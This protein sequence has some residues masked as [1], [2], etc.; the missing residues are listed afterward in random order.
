MKISEILGEIQNRAP[1]G[2]AES[3]DNVGLLAGDLDQSTRGAVVAI[4]LNRRAIEIARKKKFSLI[5][6]HHPAIFPTHRGLSRVVREEQ[7]GVSSLVY[8]AIHSGISVVACHTNFDRCALEVV[9]AVAHG[10]GAEPEG[11][12]LEKGGAGSLAKLSVFVPKTHAERVRMAVCEAGAGQIGKYDFC[13]FGT[14]GI[15]TFR[16]SADTRPFKGKPGRLEKAQEI[17]LETLVPRGLERQVVAALLKAH[18]Y[19][20]VAWD[21]FPVEQT[22]PGT[23]L[24]RGLGYGFWGDLR[25]PKS[26]SEVAQDVKS[27]FKIIGFCVT[28]PVPKRIRRVAFVAGKGSSFIAAAKQAGCD[29]FITG[30]AGYHAALDGM[31]RGLGVMEIG[32]RESERFFVT[33]MMGWLSEA[34]IKAVDGNIATQKF[35]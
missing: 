19:E 35:Y 23:G 33:T 12:L 3:W 27:L 13:T 20:E 18:P 26:F 29:L 1:S 17:R 5:V 10:L 34:G 32:H 11:R 30:E 9:Q 6:T 31:S 21:L 24:I 28:E 7:G 22:P 8:E 16:G 14:E 2:T 25:R 4:D 15:G